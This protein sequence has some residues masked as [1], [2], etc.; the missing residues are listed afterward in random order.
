VNLTLL[1]GPAKFRGRAAPDR[2]IT[3]RG[4]PPE[5][6]VR[7]LPAA[8]QDHIYQVSGIGPEVPRS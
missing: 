8:A 4:L 5:V 3:G 2:V 6:G 1:P 7:G